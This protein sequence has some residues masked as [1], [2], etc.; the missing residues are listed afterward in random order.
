MAQ[1]R[2]VVAPARFVLIPLA[3]TLIG[4]TPKAIEKKIES[5]TWVINRQYRKAP[6]GRIY[7]DMEGHTKW[8]I[9]QG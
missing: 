9:G 4:T 8:V 7:V 5:G 3:A 6:D 2:V 1:E